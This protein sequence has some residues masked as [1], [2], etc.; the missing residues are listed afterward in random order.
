MSLSKR[1]L[2]ILRL[3]ALEFDNVR[4]AKELFISVHTVE[5]H[6]RNIFRKTKSKT[7]VGLIKYAYKHQL[8]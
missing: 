6:R 1:E 3:I 7:I 8:I 4:I 5:T 2:E